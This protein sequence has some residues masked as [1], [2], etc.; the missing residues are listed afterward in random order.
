M[1]GNGSTV[2]LYSNLFHTESMTTLTANHQKLKCHN[3]QE[4]IIAVKNC[5]I[6]S[7]LYQIVFFGAGIEGS[8]QFSIVSDT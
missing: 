5:F 7:I 3:N 8:A 4:T 1:K 2:S 6:Q